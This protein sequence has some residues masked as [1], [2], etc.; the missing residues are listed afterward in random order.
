MSHSIPTSPAP[1]FA[2]APAPFAISIMESFILKRNRFGMSNSIWKD[3]LGRSLTAIAGKHGGTFKK[4]RVY[5]DERL[6][7]RRASVYVVNEVTGRTR[8]VDLTHTALG[9]KVKV[10]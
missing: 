8:Y 6:G 2:E 4:G 5:G 9:I 1:L 3:A 10:G 7:W